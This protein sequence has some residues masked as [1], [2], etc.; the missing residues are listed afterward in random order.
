MADVGM[1]ALGLSAGWEAGRGVTSSGGR[2][3]SPRVGKGACLPGEALPSSQET[4]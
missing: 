3:W 2:T 1:T 4:G